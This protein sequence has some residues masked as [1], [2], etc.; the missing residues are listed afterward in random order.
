MDLKFVAGLMLCG[1]MVAMFTVP[2]IL[3]GINM[4]NKK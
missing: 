3:T 2:M 4:T 1:V